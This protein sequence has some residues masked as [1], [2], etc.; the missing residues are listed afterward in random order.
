[1]SEEAAVEEEIV[2]ETPETQVDETVMPD[3]FK[4]EL[5]D[6]ADQKIEED[7][8]RNSED[9]PETDEPG[10]PDKKPD[11]DPESDAGDSSDDGQDDADDSSD[12]DDDG[13]DEPVVNEL[14]IE[15]AVRAGMSLADAKGMSE[16][17]LGRVVEQFE[18]LNSKASK[19]DV[20]SEDEVDPVEEMLSKIPDLDPE[21]YSEDVV[22]AFS[23]MKELIKTQN[24]RLKEIE[25]G[26][27]DSDEVARTQRA[28]EFMGWFD[29]QVSGLGSDYEEVLGKG[30]MRELSDTNMLKA[31]DK[32]ALHMDRIEQD[33]RAEGKQLPSREDVFKQAVESAFP[34][35]LKEIKDAEKAAKAAER[36]KRVLHQPRDND[37]GK[38]ISAE[39]TEESRTEEA[40]D[41]VS[42]FFEIE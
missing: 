34:N 4:Q 25:N 3:D 18:T 29:G 26:S 23:G 10:S 33:I 11:P 9:L 24:D 1:M 37:S 6:L 21:E 7:R 30:G 22:S 12:E 8:E 35:K 17:T 40:I 38:F 28:N 5:E 16:D 32:V 15:R 42:K 36:S 13:D 39:S 19:D 27:G 14:L 2:D 41:A 31:R 20:D